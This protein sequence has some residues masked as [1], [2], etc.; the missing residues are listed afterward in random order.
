MRYE[1]MNDSDAE[2]IAPKEIELTDNPECF[3]TR[4]KCLYVLK[5]GTRPTKKLETNKRRK[6]PDTPITW[7]SIIYPRFMRAEFPPNLTE[8]F[9]LSTSKNKLLILMFSLSYLFNKA[10]Y[11]CNKTGGTFSPMPRK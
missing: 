10:T 1:L 2:F 3:D 7:K 11:I 4:S 9:E 6:N 5:E 8:A